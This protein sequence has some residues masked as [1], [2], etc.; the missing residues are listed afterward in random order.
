MAVYCRAAARN[1]RRRPRLHDRFRLWR[2]VCLLFSPSPNLLSRTSDDTQYVQDRV[3]TAFRLMATTVTELNKNPINQDVDNLHN[4][5]FGLPFDQTKPNNIKRHFEALGTISQRNDNDQTVL[6]GAGARTI[7]VK[8]YCSVKR[9]EK[10]RNGDK[11]EYVNK[12]RNIVYKEG[13]LTSPGGSFANCFD[14][15]EPTM[16]LT[17]TVP[18]QYSEIQICPWYLRKARGFRFRDL[19]DIPSAA[20]QGLGKLAIPALG[21][22]FYTPID[23]FVLTDKMIVHELTHTDQAVF[24]TQDMAPKAYGKLTLPFFS[25]PRSSSILRM[26]MTFLFS[27]LEE[28]EELGS[29]LHRWKL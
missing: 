8:F 6:G 14:I 9:I 10:R 23:M 29:N 20:M 5:L 2:Y 27:R 19:T 21:K 4:R 13:E 26:L 17:L 18:D 25:F 1:Q 15:L 16:M 7:D 24:P 3:D 12:D 28:R 22:A 11:T